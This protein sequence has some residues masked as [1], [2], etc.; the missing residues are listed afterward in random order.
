MI[1]SIDVLVDARAI[2]DSTSEEYVDRDVES[3]P[4]EVPQSLVDSTDRAR[5]DGARRVEGGA[6]H[7]VPQVLNPRGVLS[8]QEVLELV[9]RCLD[10]PVSALEGRLTESVEP[11]VCAQDK[12][13]VPRSNVDDLNLCDLRHGC[14]NS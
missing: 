4:H 5:H 9:D 1:I 12:E 3:L 7:Q 14:P 6:V 13:R 10:N 8:Q 2:A 11:V